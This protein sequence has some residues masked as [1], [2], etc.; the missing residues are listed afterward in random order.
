MNES[1]H[2]TS[3]DGS[4]TLVVGSVEAGHVPPIPDPS[5]PADPDDVALLNVSYTR[6][7]SDVLATWTRSLGFVPKTGAVVSVLPG[8]DYDPAAGI[9]DGIGTSVVTSPA[10]L[11][12]IGV[13][14][15]AHLAELVAD[16][17]GRTL[18][19][20]F[21]SVT[22][23]LQYVD[24]STAVSFLSEL[25]DR[26]RAAGALGYFYVEPDALSDGEFEDVEAVF[27]RTITCRG[28]EEPLDLRES[29]D[30]DDGPSVDERP[31]TRS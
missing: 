7:P 12:S 22:T 26:I 5:V 28:G 16:S 6:T 24:T 30:S 8:L 17:D 29:T 3:T 21:D 10:D 9:P 2:D 11:S 19:V 1:F 13:E 14:I 15:S 4:V 27:A 25:S 18:L 23:L 31:T 20:T